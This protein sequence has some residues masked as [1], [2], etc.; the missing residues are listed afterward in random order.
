MKL[1]YFFLLLPFV[2]FGQSRPN[3]LFIMSDDHA[4][5]AL[6]CYGSVINRTPNLD[7][8]A[9]NGMLFQHAF[10]T[11]SICS[12]VRAVNLTGKL[13]HINGVLDNIFPFD[14]A[15]PTVPK[16]LQAA[17]YQT[18]MIGKWHLKS[19]PTGFDHWKILID[20]GEYFNPRFKENGR[21]NKTEGYVTNLITDDALAWLERRDP[22]KPFFMMLHHK[23]PHRNWM[24]DL[25]YLNLYDSILIPEPASLFDNYATRGR[26]AREQEMSLEKD[27]HLNYDLKVWQ[28]TSA[29]TEPWLKNGM[30][31]ELAAMT[32]AQRRVFMEAYRDEN[33]LFIKN[34]PAGEAL[35]RWKYQRYV[36]DYLRCVASVDDQVGRVLDYLEKSGMAANTIVVYTSD[37]GFYLGEHG[38]FDKR[39]MYEE[40]Y[41]QPLLVQW[42]GHIPSGVQSDALVMNLDFAP[43]LLDAAGVEV[44]ADMQGQSL[45]PIL[46]SASTPPDWRKATYYHYFEYPGI[47]AVKRHYGVRTD[48]YKLIHFYFNNDEWELYDLGKDPS[49]L[50]NV[51]TKNEYRSVRESL[52][53]TLDSLQIVYKDFPENYLGALEPKQYKHKALKKAVQLTYPSEKPAALK[54]LTDGLYQDYNIYNAGIRN[55][56]AAFREKPFEGVI[57]LGKSRDIYRLRFHFMQSPESWIY[58]PESIEISVSED[59]K[60]YE[61]VPSIAFRPTQ[62]TGHQWANLAFDPR[63]ARYVKWMAKGLSYIPSGQP[64]AGEKAWIFCDEVA[65]E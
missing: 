30:E 6:S 13:S 23:A 39:F 49:E 8:I 18:A 62:K 43:T 50:N 44:P 28:D 38:W 64:G 56:Y 54:S 14:G 48:R 61:P 17:G 24:P 12:P 37:Q 11:N 45:K 1:I 2:L 55:G 27:M 9:Q 20:Q 22:S 29:G 16:Y 34:R 15:Q 21:I 46:I 33:E 5:Q 3:I 40:S 10:C 36:K 47:H 58:Y 52:K 57:D 31:R 7:R 42:P 4:T 63:S 41:R 65:V 60:T 53:R 32:A 59:G 19:D 51:Y 35:V 25:P 26:A